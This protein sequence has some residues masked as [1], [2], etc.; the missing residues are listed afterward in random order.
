MYF[1]SVH[2]QKAA[3]HSTKK[4]NYRR[5]LKFTKAEKHNFDMEMSSLSVCEMVFFKLFD[6][7]ESNQNL[8]FI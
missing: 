4:I 7:N 3:S 1:S 6:C 8:S 2:N 5:K